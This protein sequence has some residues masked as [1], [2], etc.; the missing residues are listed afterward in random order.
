MKKLI[1]LSILLLISVVVNSKPNHKDRFHLIVKGK[2]L[3]KKHITYTILKEDNKGVFVVQEKIKANRY[4]HV[5][6]N[7]GERYI[8]RFED[9]QH[10]IKFLMIEPQEGGYFV[11]DVDFSKSYNARLHLTKDG[12]SLL[13]F[14]NSAMTRK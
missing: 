13:P 12:Y 7:V 5:Q 1:V 6:C 10:N 2:F 4:Y 11:A 14:T 9:R 8:I 3:V